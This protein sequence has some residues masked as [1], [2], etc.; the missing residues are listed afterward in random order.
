MSATLD[1]RPCAD[2][3]CE[4]SELNELAYDV[5][6]TRETVCIGSAVS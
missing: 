2:G 4:S 1:A 3:K 5:C 6:T